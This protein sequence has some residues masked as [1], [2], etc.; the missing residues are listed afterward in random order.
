MIAIIWL[1]DFS[2]VYESIKSVDMIIIIQGCLLQ[3]ITIVLVNVQWHTIGLQIG[4]KVS[5]KDMFHINM[6]GTFTESVTPSVKAGG[7]LTKIIM[8]KSIANISGS[9]ATAIVGVQKVLSIFPF[10]ALNIVA[11]FLFII[12]NPNL[13]SNIINV[14]II[15]FIVL[16]ILSLIMVLLMIY[17]AK[18]K[19]ITKFMKKESKFKEKIEH[20][21]DNFNKSF[22]Q[23]IKNKKMLVFQTILSIIIWQ[24]FGLKSYL[25]AKGLHMNIDLIQITV[26][27]YLTYM[28]A[29]IPLLP[30]GA[31]SFEGTMVLLLKA[32]GI[33]SYTGM[34]F[35]I[36]VRF[37]TFWFVFIIS[38]IYLLI[39]QVIRFLNK[40][41]A[42]SF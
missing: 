29:M 21:I 2:K 27:T 31:G 3:I 28:V 39:Y 20:G 26:I 18:I 38:A 42:V 34:A 32:I 19:Y 9:K 40:K 17:P 15:A 30:G 5:F 24:F 4:E 13:S 25:I 22:K 10:L 41:K 23:M 8:L 1:S 14:I 37:V 33:A 35:S 16:T 36:A 7:E 11:L 12:K 6:A